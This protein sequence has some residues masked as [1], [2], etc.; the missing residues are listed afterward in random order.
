MNHAKHRVSD[1]TGSVNTHPGSSDSFLL[2]VRSPQIISH[3]AQA[4][5]TQ[6]LA[7]LGGTKGSALSL[8]SVTTAS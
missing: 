3:Q 6:Y 5:H 7:L 1:L 2:S 4:S 8:G